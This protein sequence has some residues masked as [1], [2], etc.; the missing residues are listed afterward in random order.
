MSEAKRVHLQTAWLLHHRPFRDTSRLLDVMT[1]EHGR[2][3]LVA[4]GS[5][6]AKSKLKGVLRPFLPL[7]ISWVSR[8]ELGTLTGAEAA[9]PPLALRG[10]ALM[11]AY[12]LNE[13]IMH[14]LHRHDPH[15]EVFAAYGSTLQKLSTTDRLAAELRSFEIDLLS[16][17]GY[18]VVLEHDNSTGAELLDDLRYEYH[19]ESGPMPVHETTGQMVFTGGELKSIAE[20]NFHDPGT[21]QCAGRLMRGVIAYHLN[22]K[23]LRSRRVL[24]EVHSSTR[25]P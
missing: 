16:W 22:G 1:A 24:R 4:R 10:D 25:A 3:S 14:L 12:Y 6:S 8:T 19:P 11:A 15:P 13:L 2:I 23:E 20:R 18:G 5:R 21:L 17:V 7:S 9:G